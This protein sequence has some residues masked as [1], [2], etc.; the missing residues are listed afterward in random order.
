[1]RRPEVTL[2][3]VV[4]A[5]GL[6]A[7]ITGVLYCVLA[8]E[9]RRVAG[10]ITAA[11]RAGQPRRRS[12]QPGRRPGAGAGRPAVRRGAPERGRPRPADRCAALV[13]SVR[14]VDVVGVAPGV[15]LGAGIPVD[16]AV[17]ASAKRLRRR[18]PV[19]RG[20]NQGPTA[21]ASR[22]ARRPL[23]HALARSV[24]A[25]VGLVAFYYALP[26]RP[27]NPAAYL[28]LGG[29]LVVV[30]A[31]LFWQVRHVMSSA[32]SEAAGRGGGRHDVAPLP[33]G[34]RRRALPAG[35]RTS[36]AATPRP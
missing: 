31:L 2:S 29:G 8:F 32:L 1:M 27:Q 4:V 15:R 23:V 18:S 21:A 25:C 16:A 36:P 12:G 26:L 20:R 7:V 19:L 30:M 3:I 28:W 11:A 34:V 33:A 6:W 9:V 5:L 35:A 24:L 22:L 13:G 14:A 10:A 17:R